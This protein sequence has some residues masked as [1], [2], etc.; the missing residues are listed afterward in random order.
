MYL[1]HTF[2]TQIF[3]F[4]VL[5]VISFLDSELEDEE[6]TMTDTQLANL[7]STHDE[8][9]GNCNFNESH[10]VCPD[11]LNSTSAVES[12]IATDH[13]SHGNQPI[14]THRTTRRMNF[15]TL[16]EIFRGAAGGFSTYCDYLNSP[17]IGNETDTQNQE[18]IT[19]AGVA[20]DLARTHNR[21]LDEK[22]YITYEIICCSFLLAQLDETGGQNNIINTYITSALG[23]STD[24]SLPGDQQSNLK[25]V[26]K[27]LKSRGGTEQ[28]RLFLT[29]PAGAGKT[30]AIKAAETFCFRFSMHVGI[31][32]TDTTF[33][34][35]A[36]TGSAASA[37]GG[38]TI[39]KASGM[40]SKRVSDEQ[41]NDWRNCKI[42][43]IDEISFMK[44]SE[45]MQLD[46][47]LKELGDR[48]KIF[49]GYSIIF[50]GDF[51]QLTKA[52]RKQLMYSK[53]S[54]QFFEHS[55]TGTIILQNEHRFKNDK[56]W[57]KILSDFWFGDLSDEQRRIINE[58]VIGVNGLQPPDNL[59]DGGTYACPTNK[60]RNSI[61]A[62]IFKKIVDTN[63]PDKGSN[64]VPPTNIIIIESTFGMST[65]KNGLIR[66]IKN[67]LRHR[68]LT[69]CG[70][71]NIEYEG[72]KKADPALCLYTGVYLIFISDNNKMNEKPP[73]GNGTVCKFI[74]VKIKDNAASHRVKTYNGKKV[75]TV[76]IEDV[77]WI[78][79]E[80]MDN[81]EEIDTL[82]AKVR[83][84]K[85]ETEEAVKNNESDHTIK[86]LKEN[87]RILKKELDI[88]HHGR[89]F[90]ITP[91]RR[92][93]EV[94]V[95]PSRVSSLQDTFKLQMNMMPVNIATAC[96]GHKLQGRS[97]DSLIVT[98]WPNFK[99]NVIFQNWEYVVLSRVRTMDGL[100]LMQPLDKEKNYAP[101]HELMKYMKRARR[102]EKRLMRQREKDIAEFDKIF[103]EKS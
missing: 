39:V 92:N 99:N 87:L 23:E 81:T 26:K 70:D 82:E 84:M 45:L 36:Y 13:L 80:L 66:R 8:V 15:N 48:N 77:Q 56:V 41:R 68:I 14:Q 51:R 96:T 103:I 49:G 25:T 78:T 3:T 91:E 61:S 17:D 98:S 79:V 37:F 71:A 31:R 32:W 53:E 27:L 2:R 57:G 9:I 11:T 6:D 63:N 1:I 86:T 62:G 4:I 12:N 74:S 93:V 34:Y 97:K 20:Q 22:Q 5:P 83:D 73:R 75:W 35:T 44:E 64:D 89:Q 52:S 28:L 46:R 42:L 10:F 94:T 21:Q 7:D 50:G 54:S 102:A 69:T 40:W 60:E 47:K 30:T 100:F 43:V 67:S 38:R 85:Q 18:N 65:S 33:F 76:S 19:I 95:R 16:L 88:M 58:R 72:S 90:K 101:T 24:S 59:K 29:G 55:L